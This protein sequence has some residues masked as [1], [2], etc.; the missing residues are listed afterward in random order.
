VEINPKADPLIANVIP[1]AKQA[2]AEQRQ[3]V[4]DYEARREANQIAQARDDAE[5][6]RHS[7][8]VDIAQPEH[9]GFWRRFARK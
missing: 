3:A 1:A 8:A 5:L 2:D 7:G 9:A 4:A 6:A